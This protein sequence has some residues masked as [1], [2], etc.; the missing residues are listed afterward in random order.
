MQATCDATA[1]KPP[2]DLGKRIA[3]TAIDEF[4]GFGGHRID[5]NGRLFHFGLTEAE[6]EEDDSAARQATVGHLGWWQVM[7]Y[8]R[9][10]FGGDPNDKLEVLGYRDAS[11]ATQ[12]TQA[13]TLLRSSAAR[14]LRLA[15]T[16]S[17]PAER[18]ILREAAIRAAVIDTSWSAAFVSYVVRQP[19]V[20]ENT[21]RFANAHRVFIYDA[22]ATSAAELA[23]KADERIYRACPIAT[24]PRPGDLI[25]HQREILTR[26]RQRR[27]G[28]RTHQGRTGRRHRHAFNPAHPLR[29]GRTCRCAGAQGLHH[30]RQRQ[31]GRHRQEAE[32]RR[33]LR[34]SAS[35]KGHCGGKG[36]WTL[37]QP[38]GQTARTA[39]CSLNDRKWFVLLQ[40]R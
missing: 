25:C 5:A 9:S 17:D 16:V 29:R 37:P 13:A 1:R 3:Q 12:D 32:L 6:H 38:A 19:G 34:F 15:E 10:L 4:N 33:G 27:R 8:W 28:A 31:S 30:R 7:K 26:R 39:K 35:Q 18:E 2:G 22:F 36:D 21:F 23:G 14:L 24:R 20:T 40:V 11:T